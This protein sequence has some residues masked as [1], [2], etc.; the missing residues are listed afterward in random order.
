[1]NPLD[2]LR[3]VAL[4]AALLVMPAALAE[5]DI[6]IGPGLPLGTQPATLPTDTRLLTMAPT[7][8]A[9]RQA[10]FGDLHIH[11]RHSLDAYTF[12]TLATPSDAYRFAKGEAIQHPSGF[13]MQ[14]KAP[15]DFYAVTDHAM[16]MGVVEAMADTSTAFSKHTVA[17]P[18]HN[19]NRPDNVNPESAAERMGLFGSFGGLLGGLA[20]GD[21]APEEVLEITRTAWRDVIDAAKQHNDPGT[22]T[23][24]VAYEYTSSTD[25]GG[26]LHRNVVFRGDDRVPQ[27]PFSRLH[28]QNPEG[29]WHWMDDLREQGVDSLAIPHN[30]NGSNGAMFMLTDWAGNPIDSAYAD[31]R[32][33]NEPLVEVTQVKGTSDTHPMLSPNDEWADFEI[34]PYRIGNPARSSAPGSYVREAYLNGLK[35]EAQTGANPYRFGLVGASDTHTGAGSFEESNFFAKIGVIDAYGVQRGSVPLPEDHAATGNA[36]GSVTEEAGQTYI[37]GAFQTWSA[38]GLAGVWAEENSRDSIFAAFRRKET[39]ATSGPRLK[40]RL[41][42]GYDFSPNM[43]ANADWPDAAYATGVPMGGDLISAGDDA[44]SLIVW[45]MRDARAAPLQRLQIVKGKEIGGEVTE[46]VFDVAC[47]DGTAVDPA[48]HR[49]PDNGATVDLATCAHS[50]DVGDAELATVWTDPTFDPAERAFYY[51]R[52]L[53]N[54]TCRWSTWDAI[55]AGVAPRPSLH[56]TLQERAWSSPIWYVP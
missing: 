2:L 22:F 51:A 3:G 13:D 19:L 17:K 35:I 44:P 24:F 40:I 1:M 37:D 36:F 14:L 7:Q 10:L 38:S 34:M 43:L 45:A 11:T 16:M 39:F 12:G 50:E 23:T 54:P 41:F 30:S 53:E 28:S 4:A 47:A 49:C 18:F 6:P 27:V 5:E 9:D 29:L 55:K 8:N 48:T 52:V 21:I 26:N 15:L 46:Q 31:L 33:R 32:M 42:A 25:E 20:N 56:A